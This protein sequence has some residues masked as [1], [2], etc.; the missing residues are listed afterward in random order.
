MKPTWTE[1]LVCPHCGRTGQAE[2][3]EN[4]QFDNSF[5]VI[6]EGFTVMSG[7][8]GRDFQC[9]GCHVPVHP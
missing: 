5:D 4:G 2:L 3:S 8:R 1:H 9:D 7:V 6:P